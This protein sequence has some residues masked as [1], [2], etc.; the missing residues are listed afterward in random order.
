MNT[1]LLFSGNLTKSTG[2][3]ISND[4][5]EQNE[6]NNPFKIASTIHWIKH[7]NNNKKSGVELS[8]KSFYQSQPS[9]LDVSPGVFNNALNDS[10]AFNAI[11]Q[12]VDFNNFKTQ[13][14][15]MLLS[16]TG[17]KLFR[18]YPTI[19]LWKLQKHLKATK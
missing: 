8:S 9:R 12:D 3:V 5:I 15:L 10:M 11:R 19:I 2:D 13:N 7:A 4:H 1:R 18:I 6:K 16:S 17:W 14:N